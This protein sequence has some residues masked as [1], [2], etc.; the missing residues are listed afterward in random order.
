MESGRAALML[1]VNC[2]LGQHRPRGEVLCWVSMKEAFFVPGQGSCYWCASKIPYTPQFSPQTE[3]RP[4]PDLPSAHHQIFGTVLQMCFRAYR[5]LAN[6]S[7]SHCPFFRVIRHSRRCEFHR[8]LA[9]MS[10]S[11]NV[12]P[13]NWLTNEFSGE[14]INCNLY[15]DEVEVYREIFWFDSNLYYRTDLL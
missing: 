9:C 8:S 2:E 4:G 6:V 11:R 1:I 14:S 10:V 13:N 3:L 5:L 7:S 12:L 15:K